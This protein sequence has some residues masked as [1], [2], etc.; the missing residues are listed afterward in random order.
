MRTQHG[1]SIQ[2]PAA[3]SARKSH[4]CR[5]EPSGHDKDFHDSLHKFTF[6]KR[7]PQNIK[8]CQGRKKNRLHRVDDGLMVTI[9]TATVVEKV[10]V[11]VV[12]VVMV[13]VGW[14]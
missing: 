11:V 12:L 5:E 4:L 2:S 6:F 3:T 8:V 9:A 10:V 1:S 7:I 14:Q 13:V